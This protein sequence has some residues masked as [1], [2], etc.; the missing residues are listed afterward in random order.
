MSINILCIELKYW[1]KSRNKKLHKLSKF[2]FSNCQNF[3]FQTLKIFRS[4]HPC[5]FLIFWREILEKSRT[6][7][8]KY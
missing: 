1:R 8:M 3:P 2:S 7:R 6:T 4:S 5:N